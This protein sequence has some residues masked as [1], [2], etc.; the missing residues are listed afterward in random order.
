MKG[1]KLRQ[2]YSLV[3]RVFYVFSPQSPSLVVQ[4]TVRSFPQVTPLFHKIILRED[5]PQSYKTWSL[6][7][8]HNITPTVKKNVGSSSNRK[9]NFIKTYNNSKQNNQASQ[10]SLHSTSTK[11]ASH[12]VSCDLQSRLW[13]LLYSGLPIAN[14]LELRSRHV[15]QRNTWNREAQGKRKARGHE[16]HEEYEDTRNTSSR[17]EAKTKSM[18]WP[19][20]THLEYKRG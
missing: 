5:L 14:W 6:S 7:T 3:N 8:T 2:H 13:I 4:S 15:E 12:L 16:E 20:S 18:L 19:H 11:V 9:L 1:N 10:A 17:G